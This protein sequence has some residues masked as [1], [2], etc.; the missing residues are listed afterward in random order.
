MYASGPHVCLCERRVQQLLQRWPGSISY[1][2][3]ITYE[4]TLMCSIQD[5][6]IRPGPIALIDLCRLLHFHMGPFRPHHPTL[7]YST[8]VHFH[9]WNR[10]GFFIQP[11]DRQ[12]GK[13]LLTSKY[14][15]GPTGGGHGTIPREYIIIMCLEGNFRFSKDLRVLFRKEGSA[16]LV[17]E[18]EISNHSNRTVCLSKYL[19]T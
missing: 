3:I 17:V 11:G 5:Y 18:L 8:K 7:C 2:H 13:H 9:H 19:T 12:Y 4:S 6:F 16:T 1:H 10:T 15:F 14:C